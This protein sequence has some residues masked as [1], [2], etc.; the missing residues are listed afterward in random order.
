MRQRAVISF[1]LPSINLCVTLNTL[2]G[3]WTCSE[4]LLGLTQYS[5]N[6]LNKS[7]AYS[8]LGLGILKVSILVLCSEAV[9]AERWP[10]PLPPAQQHRLRSFTNLSGSLSL[11]RAQLS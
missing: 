2:L 6:T 9:Q 10:G 8:E 1:Q 7:H 3:S 5:N 11:G 4:S